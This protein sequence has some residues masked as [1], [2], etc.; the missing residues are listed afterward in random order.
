VQHK[1]VCKI[2]VIDNGPGIPD[3][4]LESIF[5]PMVTGRA[6]GTGLGLSISQSLINQHGGLIQCEG[7][8]GRT[9]FSL[10]IPFQSAPNEK[11]NSQPL[12][13][14]MRVNT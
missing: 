6:E 1:L 8:P 4:I 12:K 13:T 9:K 3:D 14:T 10:L 7:Q 5:L 2:D 11:A